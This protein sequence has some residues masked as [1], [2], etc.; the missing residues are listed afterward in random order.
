D[1]YRVVATLRVGSG[2]LVNTPAGSNVVIDARTGA[3]GGQAAT[4]AVLPRGYNGDSRSAV[5]AGAGAAYGVS[6]RGVRVGVVEGNPFAHDSLAGR[7]VLRNGGLNAAPAGEHRSEH[8]LAVAGIIAARSG[9]AQARGIAPDATIYSSAMATWGSGFDLLNDLRR[10]GV[11]IVNMSFGFEPN[12]RA[13]D[14]GATRISQFVTSNPGITVVASAGNSGVPR[15]NSSTIGSPAVSG[16]VLAVGAVNRDFTA[17]AGFS[18]YSRGGVGRRPDIVAPGEYIL[19]PGARDG[20]GNGQDDEFRRS[21]IGTDFDRFQGRDISTGP[22]SGTSFAAP[23]VT[24]MVALLHDLASRQPQGHDA[25]STDSRVMRAVVMNTATTQ[26]VRRSGGG[27]WSQD[28]TIYRMEGHEGRT[29]LGVDRSCDEQLGAGLLNVGRAIQMFSR[30]ELRGADDA[31]ERHMRIDVTGGAAVPNVPMFWDRQAVAG[32]TQA[33][34][35]GMVEYMLGQANHGW[36]FRSTMAWIDHTSLV[37]D[38]LVSQY[39][40]LQLSL[41]MEGPDEGNTGGFDPANPDADLLITATFEMSGTV[42]MLDMVLPETGTYY[43]LVTNQSQV[44]LFGGAPVYGISAYIPA[45]GVAGV[46]ALAGMTV[47]RRRRR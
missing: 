22:I 8:S 30:A 29:T 47:A 41:Y 7:V 25:D 4:L 37:N 36:H 1:Q 15:G 24:G 39:S 21:F 6:G 17:R 11:R 26:N 38:Q 35:V 28:T 13:G 27:A 14:F 32:A 16:N 3:R 9:D 31:N 18:S 33:D 12:Q 46:L 44:P 2:G 43:L 45:P 20:D 23:F 10:Q 34:G 5:N 42:R 40:R 19:A